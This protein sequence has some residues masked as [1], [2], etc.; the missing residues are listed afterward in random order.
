MAQLRPA[1]HQPWEGIEVISQH[2]DR[3]S[4]A[5]IDCVKKQVVRVVLHDD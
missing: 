1:D 2:A 4:V 5:H 3:R